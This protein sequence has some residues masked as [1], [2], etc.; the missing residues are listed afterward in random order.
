MYNRITPDVVQALRQ[1]VGEGD[2]LVDA[3]AL[4]PYGHDEVVGLRAEPE[5]A[6]R[7]SSADQI[8]AVRKS[9]AAYRRGRAAGGRSWRV[10]PR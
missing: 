2:V 9:P 1:I 8:A 5:V 4:E 7:V 3:E 10:P 6:V